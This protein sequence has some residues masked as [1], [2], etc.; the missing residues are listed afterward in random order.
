MLETGVK[1][2]EGSHMGQI[3]I[4]YDILSEIGQGISGSVFQAREKAGGGLVAIKRLDP[5]SNRYE[6]PR[7]LTEWELITQLSHPAVVRAIEH[8]EEDGEKYLISEFVPGNNL[9]QLILQKGALSEGEVIEILLPVCEA[10]RQSHA[11]GLLHLNIKPQNILIGLPGKK[12]V[13]KA[14]LCDFGLWT[15]GLDEGGQGNFLAFFKPPEQRRGAGIGP[16]SDIY[17]IGKLIYVMLSGSLS[18]RISPDALPPSTPFQPIIYR[19]IRTNTTDRFQSLD[20]LIQ[21][22]IQI[23]GQSGLGYSSPSMAPPSRPPSAASESAGNVS[24]EALVSHVEIKP[25]SEPEVTVQ[26]KEKRQAAP[27]FAALDMRASAKEEVSTFRS[28]PLSQE[29][30][31]PEPAGTYSKLNPSIMPPLESSPP[32][33]PSQA[34]VTPQQRVM[35]EIQGLLI[36]SRKQLQNARLST[37]Q[38]VV[39][40]AKN[41]LKRH[42]SLQDQQ[43]LSS[44][45]AAFQE[46]EQELAERNGIIE[47]LAKEARDAL[48]SQEYDRI[49]QIGEEVRQYSV[50]HTPVEPFVKEAEQVL[51]KVSELWKEVEPAISSGDYQKADQLCT[52][53]LSLIPTHQEA[54]QKHAELLKL[55]KKQR[56]RRF[57]LKLIPILLIVGGIGGTY[58]FFMFDFQK[59]MVSFNK[60]IRQKNGERA[61]AI[62]KELTHR[63]PLIRKLVGTYEPAIRYLAERARIQELQE[64]VAEAQRRLDRLEEGSLS[65]GEQLSITQSKELLRDA[66][67][68]AFRGENEKAIE[69]LEKVL[70]VFTDI[71][72]RTRKNK[73]KQY[74]E[75]EKWRK[76]AEVLSELCAL[77]PHDQELKKDFEYVKSFLV[78]G[79]IV[80]THWQGKEIKGAIILLNDREVGQTPRRLDLEEKKKYVIKVLAPPQ[81]FTYFKV[82]SKEVVISGA[83][84]EKLDIELEPVDGPKPGKDWN[85]QELEMTFTG[86]VP[87]TFKMGSENGSIWEQPVHTVR[88]SYP[89]WILNVEVTQKFYAKLMKGEELSGEQADLPVVNVSWNEAMA[90]CNALTKHEL[91][92]NRIPLGYVYR[93][94]TEAEWEYVAKAGRQELKEKELVEYS[95]SLE[96]SDKKLHPTGR[97]MP[98]PW[99]IY[100]MC[101]GVQE[102]CFDKYNKATYL[103]RKFVIN[104]IGPSRGK[105]R[106][107]RGGSFLMPAGECLPYKRKGILQTKKLQDLGFRVVLAP[108]YGSLPALAEEEKKRLKSSSQ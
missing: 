4:K 57:I 95:W 3:D 79:I 105:E 85:I 30:P 26:R 71:Y 7:Y 8:I 22:L 21:E 60:A 14:R 32:P 77:A 15:F 90:F 10:L 37:C 72:I 54:S 42:A 83:M 99:K 67:D 40:E 48:D 34:A 33:P 88:I 81:H 9:Q 17:A 46:I 98:N 23:S 100:D 86:I 29:P 80:T 55:L 13:T 107:V 5:N 58:A 11:L 63:H 75:A 43:W 20:E 64:K 102:W 87:G 27:S 51:E 19:C 62:A 103:D 74:K 59:K 84:T 6:N 92:N 73:V 106:V 69:S 101:G 61:A 91:L 2:D 50:E 47:Q 36:A 41:L 52:K 70:S 82:F 108:E 68:A 45:E 35:T 97:K 16:A 38:E 1:R 78:P 49:V 25:K 76:A 31:P 104:P 53:I 18:P 96:N 65:K 93:L 66:G 24:R 94:P 39:E 28:S 44:M 89:F 56:R 12:T